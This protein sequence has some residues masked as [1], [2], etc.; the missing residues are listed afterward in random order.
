MDLFADCLSGQCRC[1]DHVKGPECRTCKEGFF[2]LSDRN[3]GGCQPCWCS[4]VSNV[5]SAAA[6]VWSTLRLQVVD[7]DHGITLLK[8]DRGTMPSTL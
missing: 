8:T 5:C 7:E 1:K 6:M 3:P 4:G 2:G